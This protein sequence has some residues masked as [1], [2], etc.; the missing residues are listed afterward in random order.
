MVIELKVLGP[1]EAVAGDTRL[2]LGGPAQRAL[3]ALLVLE[4]NDVVSTSTIIHAL[5]GDDAPSSATGIV[6]TYVWRLRQALSGV[7]GVILAGRPPG[8]VLEVDPDRVDAHRF[9]RLATD[10]RRRLDAGRPDEA[11]ALLDEALD[12][13]SGDALADLD[14]FESLRPTIVRL[15]Q[16]RLTAVDDRIDARLALG[17]HAA[18]I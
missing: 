6:R 11:L 3:L 8:Y 17:H 7:D 2:T 1:F 5:W 13:W 18:L 4:A 12:L 15:E 10:A 9:H 14:T 16:L